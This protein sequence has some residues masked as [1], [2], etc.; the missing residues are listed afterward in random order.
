MDVSFLQNMHKN[1]IDALLQK[2]QA[3]EENFI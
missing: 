1:I 2:E 3:T